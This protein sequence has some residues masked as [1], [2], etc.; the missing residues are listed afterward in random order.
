MKQNKGKLIKK[1]EFVWK[2]GSITLLLEINVLKKKP[3]TQRCH[4]N[5]TGTHCRVGLFPNVCSIKLF[6]SVYIAIGCR[7]CL[8]RFH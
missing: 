1:T 7:W 5:G 2:H 8:L 4:K 6:Q 3:Y